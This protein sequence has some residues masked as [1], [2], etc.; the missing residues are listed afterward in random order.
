MRLTQ[1]S[2]SERPTGFRTLQNLLSA[3]YRCKNVFFAFLTFFIVF[4]RFFYIYG[5]RCL[6]LS[7]V[8]VAA[9]MMCSAVLIQYR[10]VTDGQT[11]EQTDGHVTTAYT[12][13]AQRRAVKSV[14]GG[15]KMLSR[16]LR[17]RGIRCRPVSVCLSVCHTTVL[18][19]NG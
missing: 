18:D 4:E 9:V 13:L 8:V 2:V 10:R 16:E 7:C 5:P 1:F 12:A 3:A 11:D 15:R 14:K 6:G 17:C 19:Q